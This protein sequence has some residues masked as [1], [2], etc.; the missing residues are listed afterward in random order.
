V[1]KELLPGETV[2][3]GYQFMK[4]HMIFGVKVGSL[5]QKGRYVTGGHMTDPPAT[6]TYVSRDSVRIGLSIATLNGIDILLADIQNAYLT[7][8][9]KER[10]Y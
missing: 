9:C 6:A 10:I 3:V 2:P 5:K 8:P 4:C 1:F 7:S